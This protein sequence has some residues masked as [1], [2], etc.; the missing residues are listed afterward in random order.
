FIRDNIINVATWF[1]DRSGANIPDGAKSW[2]PT[3]RRFEKYN[4]TTPGW[5]TLLDKTDSEN[6]YE[7]RAAVSNSCDGRA[8]TAGEATNA[9][10]LGLTPAANYTKNTDIRPVAFGGTGGDSDVNARN[11]LSVYSKT[12]TIA[13]IGNKLAVVAYTST[14]ETAY[15]NT[16]TTISAPAGYTLLFIPYQGFIHTFSIASDGKSVS[17]DNSAVSADLDIRF[18]WFK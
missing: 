14:T 13:E 2:N 10:N 17:I 11:N 7:I 8:E 6:P 4:S 3:N 9:V 5:E 16:T 1:A 15:M 12:E 18:I